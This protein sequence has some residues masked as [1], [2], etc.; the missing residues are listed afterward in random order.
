LG[1]IFDSGS[2]RAR[3]RFIAIAAASAVLVVLA[4]DPTSGAD[5][6]T[7]SGTLSPF[8]GNPSAGPDGKGTAV[9]TISGDRTQLAWTITYT[10]VSSPITHVYFCAGSNPPTYPIGDPCAF[11]M[12]QA[13]GGSSPI[14]GSRTLLPQQADSVSSGSV[15]VELDSGVGPQVAGY[16]K[17]GPRLPNMAT[18]KGPSRDV[19]TANLLV[20]IIGGIGAF[21]YVLALGPRRRRR[22]RALL[23]E[24]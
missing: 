2:A 13:D 3:A 4:A 6:M 17:P 18:V 12:P 15:F 5:G 10:G 23:S 9:L 7:V 22:T 16:I 11:V 20:P 8:T 24:R 19:A 1:S 14:T 21:V